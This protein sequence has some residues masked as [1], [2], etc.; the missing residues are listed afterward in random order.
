MW[1]LLH[2]RADG[3]YVIH[4]NGSPY[5]VIDTDP[6]WPD[7][8]AADIGQPLPPEPGPPPLVPP[9][10]PSLTA[11]QLR[12]ALLDIGISGQDV[13]QK[14]TQNTNGVVRQKLRI[15]WEHGDSF[16]RDGEIATRLAAFFALVPAQLDAV[17]ING[18][19]L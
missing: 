5:H 3:S 19:A 12:L 1:T 14:I 16:A 10:N 8:L 7:V 11:E 18:A 13:D 6:L 15:A 9:A 2:R 17:W 4:L